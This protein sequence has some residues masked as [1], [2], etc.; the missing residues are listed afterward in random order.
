M[1]SQSHRKMSGIRLPNKPRTDE[2]ELTGED[3][4]IRP[5]IFQFDFKVLF[6]FPSS[7]NRRIIFRPNGPTLPERRLFRCLLYCGES[8]IAGSSCYAGGT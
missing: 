8:K 6:C 1:S 7:P 2:I 4:Y 3:K 5:S